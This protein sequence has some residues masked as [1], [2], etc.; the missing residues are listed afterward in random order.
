MSTKA[1][2][3]EFVEPELLWSCHFHD[4]IHGRA[5][6][7]PSNGC[8]DIFS[9]HGLDEHGASLTVEPSLEASAILLKN[10]KNWVA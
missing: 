6:G 7:D 5:N 8:G 1:L 10:S 9:C 4:S 2:K 3:N